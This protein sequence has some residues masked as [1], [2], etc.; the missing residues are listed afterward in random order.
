MER[1]LFSGLSISSS[2]DGTGFRR[3]QFFRN[4]LCLGG[5]PRRYA[6]AAA[7]LPA[8]VVPPYPRLRNAASVVTPRRRGR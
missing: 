1:A 4:A 6:L 3:S 8:A 2:L 7:I 5:T